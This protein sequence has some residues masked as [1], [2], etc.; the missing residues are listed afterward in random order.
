MLGG[1][2]SGTLPAGWYQR[3][4]EQHQEPPQ[5]LLVGSVLFTGEA[6]CV[7]QLFL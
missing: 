2:R 3:V 7:R 1:R 6:L 5:N 4:Q